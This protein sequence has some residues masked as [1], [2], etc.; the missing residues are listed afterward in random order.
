[1]NWTFSRPFRFS[2]S[3]LTLALVFSFQT[4][5]SLAQDGEK[6]F[7]AN[8]AACHHPLLKRTGPALKGA[9]ERVPSDEWLLEWVKNPQQ[10][11]DA[12]DDYALKIYAESNN[13]NMTPQNLTDDEIWAVMNYADNYVDPKQDKIAKGPVVGGGEPEPEGNVLL[14]ILIITVVL[15]ITV[16]VLWGVRRSLSNIVRERDGLE[17]I[18]DVDMLDSAMA[19]LKAHKKLTIVLVVGVLIYGGNLGWNTLSGI[20]IYQGYAPEQ[21]INFSH[22]I[23]AGQ[24][25]INCVYC[26]SSAEKGKASGIPSV[27]VC[28]NCHNAINQGKVTGTTEIAKIYEAAGYNPEKGIYD[29]PEKPI[30]WVRIHNLPDFVYFNHSQHVVI[31]KQKC[32]TCHGPVETMDVVEQYSELTMG[33]CVDC[34]RETNVDQGNGYYE[35]MHAD[36]LEKYKDQGIEKFTVEHIGGLECAKCHY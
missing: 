22:K 35:D 3:L 28:M 1:M 7:K 2:L 10:K 36:L 25:G 23:H 30:K 4:S 9:R 34:H 29:K 5:L 24:N 15:F 19:Y 33:W 32:Q 8:C 14:W 20:G 18:E 6:L 17:P 27:N 13:A 12:G 11:L 21:P 16:R 31:G 26:H